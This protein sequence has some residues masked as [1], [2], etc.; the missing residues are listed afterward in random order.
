M[1]PSETNFR[2][3]RRGFTLIE[4][5]TVI[6]IM[7]VLAAMIVGLAGGAGKRKKIG[8]VQAELAVL[9][10]A[11]DWYKE[12]KGTYPPDN[13]NNSALNPLFYELTGTV[14]DP[15]KK[16]FMTIRG[17]EAILQTS[18]STYFS[19]DG[20]VNSA[21]DKNEVQN[22]FPYMKSQSYLEIK[23]APE[24]EIL[25]VPV[26]GPPLGSP[27]PAN[28]PP[29][30]IADLSTG[31]ANPWHYVSSN[32]TNNPNSYDLWADIIIGGKTN[33]ICNWNKS[34]IQL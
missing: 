14:F 1:K 28:F 7:G 23:S 6:A 21:T 27:L 24:V 10:H 33:R 34:P 22:F 12:K 2:S 4:M 13:P 15:I 25:V 9:E 29:G 11:I 26:D 31:R 18:V 5:L 32:P 3:A 8:R 16:E 19:L 17:D 20:F 30:L